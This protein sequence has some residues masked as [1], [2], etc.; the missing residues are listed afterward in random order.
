MAIVLQISRLV[1]YAYREPKILCR[2]LR[3][4]G[5][6]DLLISITDSNIVIRL[7]CSREY[8]FPQMEGLVCSLNVE[9]LV[10]E[11]SNLLINL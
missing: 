3:I 4:F 6:L 7:C 9:A 2:I 11:P 10:K 8:Y 1:E 5:R